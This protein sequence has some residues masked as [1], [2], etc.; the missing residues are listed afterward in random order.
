MSITD[1]KA[2]TD[3]WLIEARKLP[4]A[5][6]LDKGQRAKR[7]RPLEG[8]LIHNKVNSA[9]LL[10]AT[11]HGILETFELAHINGADADDLGTWAGRGDVLSCFLGLLHISAYDAC[12]C[13]QMDEST[14][15]SAADGSCASSAKDNFVR[16]LVLD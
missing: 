15:L 10:D 9:E 1:L 11:I 16:Y 7:C 5:P 14:N 8:L 12:I 2:L 13:A 3:S 6:A 4:A